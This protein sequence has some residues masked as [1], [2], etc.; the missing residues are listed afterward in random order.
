M[1]RVYNIPHIKI[2]NIQDK[3]ARMLILN[4]RR[5]KLAALLQVVDEKQNYYKLSKDKNRAIIDSLVEKRDRIKWLYSCIKSEKTHLGNL[6]FLEII[7][8]NKYE[9]VLSEKEV[10]SQRLLEREK[11]LN[12]LGKALAPFIGVAK[13]FENRIDKVILTANDRTLWVSDFKNLLQAYLGTE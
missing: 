6:H 11:T 1:K 13:S 4:S 8:R 5:Q 12:E 9:A 3:D 10:L 7:N 2:E